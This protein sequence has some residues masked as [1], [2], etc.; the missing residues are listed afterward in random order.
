MKKPQMKKE[1]AIKP[2]AAYFILFYAT[3]EAA[4]VFSEFGH[5]RPKADGINNLYAMDIDARYDKDE[6]VEYIDNYGNQQ[7]EVPDW[8]ED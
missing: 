3:Q 1:A 8:L 5:I 4:D 7:S 6:V 2:M